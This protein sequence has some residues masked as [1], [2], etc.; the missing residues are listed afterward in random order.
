MYERFNAEIMKLAKGI[1]G[2]RTSGEGSGDR[3]EAV[4]RD[5]LREALDEVGRVKRENW[6]LR[7]E[8]GVLRVGSGQSLGSEEEREKGEGRVAS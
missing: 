4:L 2:A 7:R 8:V 3:G 6:A 1:K 5:K